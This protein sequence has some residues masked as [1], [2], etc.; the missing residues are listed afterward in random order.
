MELQ[1]LC[2]PLPPQEVSRLT[3]FKVCWLHERPVF[4]RIKGG[5]LS[6]EGFLREVRVDSHGSLYR[7]TWNLLMTTF[8]LL[9][10]GKIEV[11]PLAGT[12]KEPTEK[13]KSL[14]YQ[15]CRELNEK[16]VIPSTR[17]GA[18]LLIKHLISRR[19]AMR[20]IRVA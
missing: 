18:S 6:E 7:G 14:I 16:P 19:R 5:R 12:E 2:P 3:D 15:L 20:K 10:M 11:I 13:Q 17:K 8:D 9:K 4:L 1:L